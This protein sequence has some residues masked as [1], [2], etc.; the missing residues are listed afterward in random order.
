MVVFVRQWNK[1]FFCVTVGRLSAPL[2]AE[3]WGDG[4]KMRSLAD[5]NGTAKM[6]QDLTHGG[7]LG[8]ITRF[9]LP[10][11][12]TYFLQVLYGLADLYVI[13]LYCDADSTAAVTNGVQVMYMFTVIMIALSMGSTVSVGKAV[14]ARDTAATSRAIGNTMTLFSVL[15]IVSAAALLGLR[16]EIIEAIVTPRES[17]AGASDYLGV[18]FAGIPF[19]VIYNV[20]ASVFRGL[21]D[22]RRPMYFVAIAC[23]VNIILDFILIGWAGLGPRGA[24][25][26]TVTSQTLSV[27][28]AA[29]YMRKSGGFVTL[30]AADFAP[31]R[32]T[33]WGI[34]RI[35][36]PVALQDGFIQ[37][38]FLIIMMI[39]N[40]RGLTDA[41]A[42]GIVEKFI[43]IL[44]IVP[45]AMLASVS[46]I[47]AQSLGAGMENRARAT[48]R[49]A[50][51]IA[52]G[53]GTI[54]ATTMQMI[55]ERAVGLF[56]NDADVVRMGGGY[57]QGYVWDCVL[58]GIHFCFSGYF[59]A[60]GRAYISFAHNFIAIVLVRVPLAYWAS[61]AYPATLY[62]MGLVTCGGSL[63]SAV[64]CV[65][66]YVWMR[67][68]AV[69]EGRCVD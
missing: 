57:L 4:L 47:G 51:L 37:L 55:P 27:G 17:V 63:L 8:S 66:V 22:T 54:I 59:T 10:Y 23:G 40:G 42:V 61:S 32:R 67:R 41:A 3:G 19:V 34:L 50:T 39:A 36:I 1:M 43:G 46:A 15:G 7:I 9:A 56:T 35:G 24:A 65:G 25:L 58:A 31:E 30:K 49:T 64:I 53:F 21:G 29:V 26:A 14:G 68:K 13:G 44:F 33:M 11:M 62:P 5:R 60:C 28:V 6:R 69:R 48:L 38:S 52:I 20:I 45:S 2:N 18:C 16:G 12:L